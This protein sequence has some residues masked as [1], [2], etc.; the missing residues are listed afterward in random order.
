[1]ILIALATAITAAAPAPGASACEGPYRNGQMFDG[2]F[3]P[4]EN[5]PEL[6]IS[7]DTDEDALVRL[8]NVASPLSATIHV[9]SRSGATI[10]YIP[11]GQYEVRVAYG[12]QIGADCVTLQAATSVVRMEQLQE[13]A[14]EETRTP[15]AAGVSIEKRWTTGSLRLFQ[16]TI[17][18]RAARAG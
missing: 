9:S 15:T 12:G 1:M 17:S 2:G 4:G 16:R 13:F 10:E 7:N 14:I 8:Q 18:R 3:E 6:V 11:P 5:M